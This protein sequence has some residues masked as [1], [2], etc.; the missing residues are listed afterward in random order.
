MIFEKIL[1]KQK[2]K[3]YNKQSLNR[4]W[5][6]VHWTTSWYRIK[7]GELSYDYVISSPFFVSGILYPQN[8]R[9]VF[10]FQLLNVTAHIL[11]KRVIA[12]MLLIRLLDNLIID[13]NLAIG[14]PALIK[15][16][17]IIVVHL[18]NPVEFLP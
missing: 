2:K 1:D 8:I 3:W 17:L 4:V 18:E 12:Q 11:N 5:I 6:V 14:Q 10:D 13:I 7:V 15:E 9:L 16:L